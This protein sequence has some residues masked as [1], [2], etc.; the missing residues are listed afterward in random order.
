MAVRLLLAS[1][2]LTM[3][4]DRSRAEAVA[5]DDVTGTVLAVGSAAHCRSVVG[6]GSDVE[7]VDLGDTVLAPGFIEPHSHPVLSGIS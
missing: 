3:D 2:V 4:A 6:D 7:V 5:V 1:T